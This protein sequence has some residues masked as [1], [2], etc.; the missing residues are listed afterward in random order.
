MSTWVCL[1][2]HSCLWT[3]RSLTIWIIA[4]ILRLCLQYGAARCF[5]FSW[6]TCFRK[7]WSLNSW[8]SFQVRRSNSGLNSYAS[9][10][11][12]S[13]AS[14][15]LAGCLFQKGSPQTVYSFAG[16][17]SQYLRNR[18]SS[19]FNSTRIL[20]DVNLQND[21][22]V[23]SWFEVLRQSNYSPVNLIMSL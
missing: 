19:S 1:F 20:S 18:S 7:V 11:S 13:S 6:C 10:L 22:W 9:P 15:F 12:T 2:I 21:N 8:Y 17:L 4:W 16:N 14:S 5:S 3:S 23:V